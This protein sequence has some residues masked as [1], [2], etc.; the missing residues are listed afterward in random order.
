MADS[1]WGGK[2]QTAAAAAAVDGIQPCTTRID[3]GAAD[4]AA[5]AS[6]TEPDTRNEVERAFADYSGDEEFQTQKEQV[7][8]WKDE[9][10]RTSE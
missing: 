1:W 8:K 6:E 3:T 10:L 9:L 4:A 2:K 7:E 5:K